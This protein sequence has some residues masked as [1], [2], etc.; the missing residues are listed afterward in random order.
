M[1][2]KRKKIPI[3]ILLL[4]ILLFQPITKCYASAGFSVPIFSSGN[5]SGDGED[6][7][8]SGSIDLGDGYTCNY[9]YNF[10]STY[11]STIYGYNSKNEEIINDIVTPTEKILSGTAM[12]V[13][14]N[15]YLSMSWSIDISVNHRIEGTPQTCTKKVLVFDML[16]GNKKWEYKN[17]KKG[18]TGCNCTGG[19]ST[20]NE[21][22]TSGPKYNECVEKAEEASSKLGTPSASY[23]IELMNSNDVNDKTITKL[24]GNGGCSRGK[25]S[26]SC[27]FWYNMSKTCINVKNSNVRYLTTN[28]SCNNDEMEIKNDKINGIEHWHYFIPLNTKTNS[29][30]YIMVSNISDNSKKDSAFCQSLID[31]NSNYK[32]YIIKNGEGQPI[33]LT[34]NKIK[35]KVEVRTG[36][37]IGAK[38]NIPINQ[39]FYHEDNNNKFKGFNFYYKPIDI[40]NPFPNGVNTSSMWYEWNKNNSK[41]PDLTKSYNKATYVANYVNVNKVR[42][43]TKDNPYTSWNNMNLNGTS[44]FIENENIVNRLVDR[45]SFYKLGCGPSNSDWSECKR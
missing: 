27:N 20:I 36:C 2:N 4:T 33:T 31:N 45:N 30:F 44:Q 21:T 41:N 34:G 18:T 3:M 6:N 15:E 5:S 38:I 10:S 17:C 42:N 25:N 22:I 19:P 13:A 24:K 9:K 16:I 32:D 7:G 23:E 35:D 14:I 40:N 8:F 39:K 26:I 12:G 43:Y 1:I 28:E 29:D 37:Y 11:N